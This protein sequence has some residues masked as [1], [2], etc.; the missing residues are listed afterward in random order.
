MNAMFEIIDFSSWKEYEGAAEGSGRSE[1][2]WLISDDGHIGLFKFP[3]ID[4]VTK[5]ETTE[6]ISEH[7]AHQ[8]GNIV[9]VET[10]TI[11]MGVYEGRIGSMSYLVKKPNE[12][13]IEGINF[14]SGRYPQYNAESMR[15]ED[16][17]TYYCL[18]QILN[19]LPPRFPI[20][21]LINMMLF[22]FL[23]GNKDR[24]QSNWAILIRLIE[25]GREL[26]IG[27]KPCPLYDNGS[28]L[29]CYVREDQ[30]ASYLGND[31]KRFES[32]VDSG[33]KSIIRIDG[34]RKACPRHSDVV[35]YLI[36]AFPQ[37]RVFAQRFIDALGTDLIHALL[38]Q[39][40]EEILT[41]L[42][43]NLISRYLKKKLEILNLLLKNLE[44]EGFKNE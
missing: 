21:F 19:S 6:H 43:R 41:P 8:L 32:L 25:K 30:I 27:A 3:K 38:E 5:R 17:G 37:T 24:H 2:K 15:N 16:D 12:F 39:Y 44:G 18:E 40:P 28:S 33:S 23:I 36:S 35:K 7:L 31:V 1:K 20:D 14:I 4:P 9:G 10:A 11:D 26:S 29:C 42:K 34:T 13:L 22:D